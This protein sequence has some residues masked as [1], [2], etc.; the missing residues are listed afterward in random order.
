MFICDRGK[1]DYI[2][3]VIA[4]PP[5]E[6]SKY[7]V[8][9]LENSMVMSWLIKSM[10]NDVGEDFMYYAIAKEIWNVA[11]ASYSY[12]ENMFELFEIKGSIHDL[13]QGELTVTQYFNTL[14]RY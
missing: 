10:T 8:W 4:A 3:S 1:D 12:K 5:M 2:T 9:K 6:D 11:E 14:N 13:R 7:K